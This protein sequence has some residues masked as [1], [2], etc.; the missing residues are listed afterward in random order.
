MLSRHFLERLLV[1]P[2]DNAQIIS[3]LDTEGA[4]ILFCGTAVVTISRHPI[5]TKLLVLE[6]LQKAVGRALAQYSSVGWCSILH[7]MNLSL[8]NIIGNTNYRLV[9]V[10]QTCNP[11]YVG[12]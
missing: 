3:A 9:L 10:T 11:S 2:W 1:S 5:R 4:A 7:Q 12:G 8:P 6:S